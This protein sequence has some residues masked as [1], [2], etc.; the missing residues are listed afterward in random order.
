MNIT[1]KWH[2]P[3]FKQTKN[4]KPRNSKSNL[5]TCFSCSVKPLIMHVCLIQNTSNDFRIVISNGNHRRP[6]TQKLLR[7]NSSLFYDIRKGT[8]LKHWEP[9]IY[10]GK[11]TLSLISICMSRWNHFSFWHFLIL[12]CRCQSCRFVESRRWGFRKE[13]FYIISGEEKLFPSGKQ[14]GHIFHH[15]W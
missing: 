12:F 10:I 4:D 13:K 15:I 6:S 2:T 1:S 7:T 14:I 11:G 9:F 5:C 3:L 8:L